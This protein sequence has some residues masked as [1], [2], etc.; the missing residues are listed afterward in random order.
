MC[1]IGVNLCDYQGSFVDA[2]SMCLLRIPSATMAEAV[3]MRQGL[4]LATSQ[5]GWGVI[6]L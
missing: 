6:E 1:A 4:S 3:A 5:L 2:S